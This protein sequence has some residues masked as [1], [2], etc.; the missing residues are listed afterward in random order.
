M[1]STV[2]D[3][4]VPDQHVDDHKL[5]FQPHLSFVLMIN[6]MHNNLLCALNGRYTLGHLIMDLS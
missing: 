3:N 2:D 6:R 4:K 1:Y 5:V